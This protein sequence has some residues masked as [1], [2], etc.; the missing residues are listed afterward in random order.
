MHDPV[1]ELLTV[2][3]EELAEQPSPAM[4]ARVRIGIAGQGARSSW[5]RWAGVITVTGIALVA[6]VVW[7]TGRGSKPAQVQQ[8]TVATLPDTREPAT[9][10]PVRPNV[11]AV[12]RSEPR[13]S[14]APAAN[15]HR[16]TVVVSPDVRR[17]FDQLSREIA[18]G[19][20]TSAAFEA[21]PWTFEPV[22][23]TPLVIEP[24]IITIAVD[25]GG[26]GN[27]DESNLSN[28]PPS[29]TGSVL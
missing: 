23:I 6:V 19:R 22:V 24:T 9:V 7:Q 27:N 21:T 17:G 18:A 29:L 10:T 14:N 13:P 15:D 2:L 8:A 16:Q 11:V 28:C 4:L 20:V 26:G 3:D 12:A 25:G 1:D 5:R